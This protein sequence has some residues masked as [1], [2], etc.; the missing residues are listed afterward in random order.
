MAVSRHWYT[1]KSN[2]RNRNFS[3]ICTSNA[4]SSIR[5]R[6]ALEPMEAPDIAQHIGGDGVDT[7]DSAAAKGVEVYR[8]LDTSTWQR[9]AGAQYR[10]SLKPSTAHRVAR[11][12]SVPDTA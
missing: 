12:S 2:T 11:S 10:T 4:V 9:R 6:G 1:P 3:T 5:F 7:L 8:M